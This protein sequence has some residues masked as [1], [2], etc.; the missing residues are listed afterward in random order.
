MTELYENF[1]NA[2]IQI[3]TPWGSG[4][5]F[6]LH[7]YNL[8]VTNRHVTSGA[9]EVVISGV[10]FPKTISGLLFSDPVYDL[11]FIKVPEHVSLSKI[12]L[13]QIEEVNE[14]DDI[15]AMGHPYGLKFTATKGIISKAKRTWNGHDFIQI[16]AAIN[17]GNSGGPLID[18]KHKIIGVNTFILADGVNLG[19]ALPVNCLEQSLK[20]YMPLFGQFA[21]RCST[22]ENIVTKTSE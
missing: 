21:Y 6:Y 18:K 12:S 9:K 1:R 5:G 2:L 20:D 3:A 4:T 13:G 15:I 7:E 19:F 8:I 16:D 11:A 17:P 22:C 14:G 10:N